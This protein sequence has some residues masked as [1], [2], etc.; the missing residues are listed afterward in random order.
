[1]H[2]WIRKLA[3]AWVVSEV[4]SCMIFNIR[5]C[6][7]VR[8]CYEATTCRAVHVDAAAAAARTWCRKGSNKSLALD[9][10]ITQAVRV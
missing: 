4:F 6:H 3:L 5:A 2:R 9:T 1:M 10:A 7:D 8:L